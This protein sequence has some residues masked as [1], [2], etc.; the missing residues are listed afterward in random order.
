MDGVHDDGGHDKM[1]GMV[2]GEAVDGRRSARAIQIIHAYGRKVKV[3]NPT[4]R[5]QEVF[6]ETV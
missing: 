2:Q 6:T 1:Y 3:G 5:R 4:A